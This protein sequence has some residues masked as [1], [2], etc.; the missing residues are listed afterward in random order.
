[1]CSVLYIH[2]TNLSSSSPHIYI[3]N[4]F[5]LE[6][7]QVCEYKIILIKQRKEEDGEKT[8]KLST[9]IGVAAG[10]SCNTTIFSVLSKS[11]IVFAKSIAYM[12]LSVE[13][14]ALKFFTFQIEI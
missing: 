8:S 13:S 14:N 6:L 5:T 12:L 7:L 2:H 10:A 9:Y 1:M 11:K 4:R 3:F